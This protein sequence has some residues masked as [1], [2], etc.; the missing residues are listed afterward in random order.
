[1]SR[2]VAAVRLLVGTAIR[3]DPAR[4]LLVLVV[5]PL[6]GAANTAQA[7]SLAWLIDAAVR[8][9]PG[10]ALRGAVLLAVTVLATHQFGA[11]V[12]DVR[13]VLQQRVGLELDRRMMILCATRPHIDHHLD[14]AY[15]DQLT[16]LRQRRSE[17]EGGLAA[18]VENA[19]ALVRVGTILAVL[20]SASP[21][22]LLMPLVALPAIMAARREQAL[23][24]AAERATAETERRRQDLFLLACDPVAAREIRLYRLAARIAAGH[25][26]AV[27]AVQRA[28]SQAATRGTMG[29]VVAWLIFAAGLFG[30]A[31]L[32]VHSVFTGARSPGDAV[33]VLTLGARFTGAT[34]SLTGLASWLG[35]ALDT[36]ALY[37]WLQRYPGPTATGVGRHPDRH[38]DGDAPGDGDAG[39]SGFPDDGDLVLSDVTF[40]YPNRPDAAVSHVDLRIPAGAT[41]AVVGDNG[42]GKST[43]VAL[44][45]GLYAPSSGEITY[46]GRPLSGADPAVWRRR[47][48]A[49]FQDFCRFELRLRETVGL[50]DLAAMGHADV[51]RTALE[52]AG[53]GELPAALP[54][55]LDTQLGATFQDGT[56]LSAGQWQ[57]TAL[58]RARMRHTPRV[59]VL[60]EPSA[61]LDPG[62]EARLIEAYL[63][64][65]GTGPAITL[66]VSHRLVTAR[67]VD[68]VVVVHHGVVTEVGS[69]AE[70]I[71][72]GGRYAELFS[73]QASSFRPGRVR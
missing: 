53:A 59:L 43:L 61:S 47:L 69:H 60:D 62:T 42:A 32:V 6:L 13:L 19:R 22:L 5:G 73:L 45:A 34:T 63:D 8:R 7:V 26:S 46:G 15:L 17:L 25:R 4:A 16:L 2:A 68:L 29:T 11:V 28:R 41:V 57:K 39:D 38:M 44:I 71:R 18:V 72:A 33:L 20:L 9:D 52:R 56:D 24:A 27:S 30:G 35:R 10:G 37:G 12:A 51:V 31:A 48:S 21:A 55:G 50:G 67:S 54:A 1:M 64:R 3:V 49:C 58:A 66:I 40:R 14:S 70:L 23:L 65:S 36:A